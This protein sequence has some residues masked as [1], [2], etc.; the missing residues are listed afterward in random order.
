MFSGKLNNPNDYRRIFQKYVNDFLSIGSS[1]LSVV[2]NSKLRQSEK[3]PEFFFAIINT[4][5]LRKNQWFVHR[6]F[7]PMLEPIK[8]S[9]SELIGNDHS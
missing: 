7:T 9:H 4:L 1:H 3:L 6:P 5:E 2:I 8:F